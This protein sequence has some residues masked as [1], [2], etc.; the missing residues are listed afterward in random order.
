MKKKNYPNFLKMKLILFFLQFLYFL[1]HSLEPP[2][3]HQFL[4]SFLTQDN[5]KQEVHKIR[6]HLKAFDSMPPSEQEKHISNMR[7]SDSSGFNE[8]LLKNRDL[9]SEKPKLKHVV[10]FFPKL[11]FDE[12]D[13][14]F[15]LSEEFEHFLEEVEQSYNEDHINEYDEKHIFSEE[16]LNE[17]LLVMKTLMSRGEDQESLEG[18]KEKRKDKPKSGKKLDFVKN[19][20]RERFKDL[21]DRFFEEKLQ[22]NPEKFKESLNK[23]MD[24]HKEHFNNKS[25]EHHANF[26]TSNQSNSSNFY[27]NLNEVPIPTTELSQNH[28]KS[29]YSLLV[30][31]IQTLENILSTQ[32]LSHKDIQPHLIENSTVFLSSIHNLLSLD[33]NLSSYN[34]SNKYPKIK[35]LIENMGTPVSRHFNV[36]FLEIRQDFA[37]GLDSAEGS[38]DDQECISKETKTAVAAAMNDLASAVEQNN[39]EDSETQLDKKEVKMGKEAAQQSMQMKMIIQLIKMVINAIVSI[40]T[41]FFRIIVP[42]VILAWFSCPEASIFPENL[43]N[44]INFDEKT[45]QLMQKIEAYPQFFESFAAEDASN[46]QYYMCAQGLFTSECSALWPG[47]NFITFLIT[48]PPFIVIPFLLFMPVLDWLQILPGDMPMCFLC[49]I[50]VLLQCKGIKFSEIPQCGALYNLD[51]LL[52]AIFDLALLVFLGFSMVPGMCSYWPFIINM[53]MIPPRLM[54][55]EDKMLRRAPKLK[56][57][58]DQVKNEGKALTEPSEE[59]CQKPKEKDR[60][61]S[62]FGDSEAASG[63]Q[64][65]E[66]EDHELD[67]GLEEKPEL[68]GELVGDWNHPEDVPD[69]WNTRYVEEEYK[70][71]H[72]EKNKKPEDT[73]KD[74]WERKMVAGVVGEGGNGGVHETQ[75]EKIEA[76]EGI[77]TV[78]GNEGE[79]VWNYDRGHE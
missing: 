48:Q 8:F 61:T 63:G 70:V 16:S 15:S 46:Q 55:E 20:H 74:E 57:L 62:P 64:E 75:R 22:K 14:D 69:K 37:A 47:F 2:Q 52:R 59:N 9:Y 13:H 50:Q 67:G 71:E 4:A 42:P 54:T 65:P 76:G 36:S 79:L 33:Q 43:I 19:E 31:H 24:I 66:P 29:N 51:T 41:G 1:A 12:K 68:M 3:I 38:P 27:E 39:Q 44:I 5:H 72:W 18:L 78:Q 30:T 21:L 56:A 53:W 6:A 7:K 23:K 10:T 11:L 49:C 40:I 60:E 34:Y 73:I 45:D 58:L 77:R 26:H 25:K 35:S 28:L 32:N 17:K